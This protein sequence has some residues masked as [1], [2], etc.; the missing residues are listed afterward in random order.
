MAK[1]RV[2]EVGMIERVGRVGTRRE[3]K[4]QGIWM[5]KRMKS[6]PIQNL[7]QTMKD[8]INVEEEEYLTF[9]PVLETVNVGL[10]IA[11]DR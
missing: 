1:N 9:W 3:V 4:W 8:T 11:S 5:L 2:E 10:M 7:H 6:T